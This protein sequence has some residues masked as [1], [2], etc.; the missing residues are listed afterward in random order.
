MWRPPAPSRSWCSPTTA[1][2]WGLVVDEI[3]DIVEEKLNIEV[4]GGEAGI[5]G[6][7]VIRGQ[8]T[9]VIDVGYFLPMAFADWFRRNDAQVSGGPKSLLLVDD[10]AF[11]RKLL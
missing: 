5:L 1:A 6:S 11:F 4:A 8:A 3:I 9:E 10:S 7:A 2:R